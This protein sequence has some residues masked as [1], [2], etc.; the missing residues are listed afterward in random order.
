MPKIIKTIPLQ[1]A[2]LSF[3]PLSLSSQQK[4][5][6]II[7]LVSTDKYITA[8][9]YTPSTSHVGHDA[10]WQEQ[11]G[12]VK[13][14]ATQT[15]GSLQRVELRQVHSQKAVVHR[16]Q[17]WQHATAKQPPRHDHAQYDSLLKV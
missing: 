6:I 1:K 11:S 3:S 12:C 10:L 5:S 4:T 7:R 9:R 13:V 2:N 16:W 15:Q 17:L 14:G 8:E